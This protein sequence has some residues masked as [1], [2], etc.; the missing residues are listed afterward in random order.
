[1]RGKLQA[2]MSWMPAGFAAGMIFGAVD[3][4]RAARSSRDLWTCLA[5]LELR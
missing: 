2:S 1:M 3:V 4:A 5:L